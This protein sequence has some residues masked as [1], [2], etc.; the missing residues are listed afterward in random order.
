MA[1]VFGWTKELVF[2]LT[3]GSYSALAK[4][5]TDEFFDIIFEIKVQEIGRYAIL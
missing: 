3:A 1:I 5:L 2:N 4:R